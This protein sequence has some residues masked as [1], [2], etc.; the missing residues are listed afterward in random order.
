VSVPLVDRECLRRTTQVRT[1]A[2]LSKIVSAL[3]AVDVSTKKWPEYQEILSDALSSLDPCVF[4]YK[5]ASN[6]T[7]ALCWRRPGTLQTPCVPMPPSPTGYR[8]LLRHF[9]LLRRLKWPLDA[10]EAVVAAT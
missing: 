1:C 3:A 2:A 6:Q 4:Y 9:S 10:D 8:R 5:R 7:K